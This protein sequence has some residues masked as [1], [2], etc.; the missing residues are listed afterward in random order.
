MTTK[1]KL[2]KYINKWYEWL[3][4]EVKANIANGKMS[5]YAGDRD[6]ETVNIKL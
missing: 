2:D 5:G 1:N 6:W 3:L 4:G